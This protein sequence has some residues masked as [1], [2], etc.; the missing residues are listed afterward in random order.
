MVVA[1]AAVVV[2]VVVVAAAAGASPDEELCIEKASLFPTCMRMDAVS[3]SIDK[4][5]GGGALGMRMGVGMGAGV[6]EK[7]D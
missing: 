7:G 5:L 4:A 3:S 2:V 6:G 1:V